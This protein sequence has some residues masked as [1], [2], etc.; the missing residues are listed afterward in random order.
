MDG[1]FKLE[2]EKLLVLTAAGGAK[3]TSFDAIGKLIATSGPESDEVIKGLCN[4][5]EE[6]EVIS[7]QKGAEVGLACVR[8][9]KGTLTTI[10]EAR[11]KAKKPILTL[12][13]K[14]DDKAKDLSKPLTDHL[15]RIQTMLNTYTTEQ[16]RLAE[17][18]ARRQREEMAKLEQQRQSTDDPAEQK[19]IVE[20]QSRVV[21]GVAPTVIKQGGTQTR[22]DPIYEVVNTAELYAARPDLCRLEPDHVAIR[23]AITSGMT[24]CPGIKDISLGLK[25]V[26][27]Q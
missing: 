6:I 26:V 14:I 13:K 27:Q 25:L 5:A 3:P 9:L 10:E 4:L 18:E 23:K 19:R 2:V 7:T 1:E 12:G 11:A 8:K 16:N 21:G 22:K 24:E 20:Q 17:V 15:N